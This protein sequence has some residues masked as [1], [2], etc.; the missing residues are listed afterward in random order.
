MQ[1][2]I[3]FCVLIL[4]LNIFERCDSYVVYIQE[5]YSYQHKYV[6]SLKPT[7]ECDSVLKL[8]Y[9]VLL[10][11]NEVQLFLLVWVFTNLL[12]SL[13]NSI[14]IYCYNPLKSSEI[15]TRADY[16]TLSI[17]S[18]VKSRLLQTSDEVSWIFIYEWQLKF[19]VTDICWTNYICIFNCELLLY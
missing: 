8:G 11:E 1:R 19:I 6:C 17:L 4:L 15:V 16:A 14:P 10:S 7:L 2:M 13:Q 9:N 18:F 3:K 5:L 12:S